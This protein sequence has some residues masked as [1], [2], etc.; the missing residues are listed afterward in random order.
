[1]DKDSKRRR[2]LEG[3][4]GRLYILQWKTKPRIA[5]AQNRR[6]LYFAGCVIKTRKRL[7]E[8]REWSPLSVSPKSRL[9]THWAVLTSV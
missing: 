1:M 5:I 3:S 7:S 4:R 2:K 8:I 9:D 6:S